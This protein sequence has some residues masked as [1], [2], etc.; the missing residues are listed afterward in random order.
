METDE[1]EELLASFMTIEINR[2]SCGEWPKIKAGV[3]KVWY[4]KNLVPGMQLG[5]GQ[6]RLTRL[7]CIP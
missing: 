4:A 2:S 5:G 6:N 1:E 3:C 7:S